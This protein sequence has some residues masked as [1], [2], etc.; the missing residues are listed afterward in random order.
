MID[1]KLEGK[2]ALIVA[3]EITLSNIREYFSIE[4]DNP[5]AFFS[6]RKYAITPTGRFDIGLVG[7][8][9]KYCDDNNIEYKID[10]EIYKIYKPS[11]NIDSISIVDGFS[12]YDYQEETLKR[13]LSNGRGVSVLATGAGKSLIAAGFCKTILD[14]NSNSKIL[15]LVP[16]LTLL[17]Q[18]LKDFKNINLNCSGWSGDCVP[19]FNSSILIATYPITL[20]NVKKTLKQIKDYDYLI[21]DECH[22]ARRNNKINKIIYNFNS[23][24]KFGLTGTLPENKLDEW[25]VIGKIGPVLYEKKSVELRN[26]TISNVK[27]KIVKLYH[28]DKPK[29]VKFKMATDFYNAEIDF[30]YTKE[31][32]N[33]FIANIAS[34]LNGNCLILVD[35]LEHGELLKNIITNTS[36]KVCEFIRGSTS[37]EDRENVKTIMESNDNIACIA[38]DSI[39]STGVSINNLKYVIF[40]CIGKAKTKVIQSIGRALRLHENKKEAIIIDIADGTHYSNEHLLKRIDMYDE[41]QIPYEIK[42]IKE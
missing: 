16:N 40:V 9:Q 38:M 10:T 7:E 17:H 30:L 4:N 29:S 24:N 8:I 36:D 22:K 26:K 14:N 6:K 18:L 21:I 42:K 32:R 12:Y 31:W 5:N 33:N 2:N 15:I 39:F 41:E 20:V 19:D 3:D 34:R 35:R 25:N 23:D 1:I 28:K 27:V 13:M 37:K 11:I